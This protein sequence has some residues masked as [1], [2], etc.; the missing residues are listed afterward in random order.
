MAIEI[1]NTGDVNVFIPPS[2]YKIRTNC[3]MGLFGVGEMNNFDSAKANG[4]G[5][6]LEGVIVDTKGFHGDL[7]MTTDS[8]WL[9]TWI[10]VTD[11]EKNEQGKHHLAPGLLIVTMFKKESAD[12]LSKLATDLEISAIL[13]GAGADGFG[14]VFRFD[15]APRSG[16]YGDYFVVNAKYRDPESDAEK[17]YVSAAQFLMNNRQDVLVDADTTKNMTPKFAGGSDTAALPAGQEVAAL[18][19]SGKKKAA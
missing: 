19:A 16:Q 14:K 5:R 1:F 11:S 7:G 10:L 15:F 6:W 8:D 12:N 18:P 17:S 13:E 9:Q 2:P 3:K 4:R